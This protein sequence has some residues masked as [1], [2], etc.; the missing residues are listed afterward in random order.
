MIL[1][2]HSLKSINKRHTKYAAKVKLNLYNTNDREQKDNEKCS[3]N[4]KLKEKLIQEL[5]TVRFLKF[6]ISLNYKF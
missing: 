4:G 1:P 2:N 6:N 3:G 5:V